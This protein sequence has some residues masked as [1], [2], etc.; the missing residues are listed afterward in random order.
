MPLTSGTRLGPYEVLAPLGAGGMGEVYRA[1]DTRLGREVAVKVLPAHLNDNPEVRARF[2]RE[3]RTISSLDHPH[4]CVL[5]DV[6]RANDTDYLVM[7]LVHGESLFDRL[8]RGPLPLADALRIG[9]EV[10]EALDRAHRAGVVHRDLKPANIMLAKSGAKLMDFGLARAA[11]PGITV[12]AGP[13]S[14]TMAHPLTAAGT[15]IGT[16]QYMAPEQLEGREADAR[17]D[18]WALGCVLYEMVAGRPA[19]GGASPA[20]ILSAI[21]KDE[22]RPLAELAPVAPSSLERIVRACLAKDPEQRWQSAHDLVLALRWP[23]GS[24]APADSAEPKAVTYRQLTF[25]RGCIIGARFASDGRT[26]VYDAAW[27]GGPHRIH[28]TRTDSPETT[29]PALPPAVLHG[30]SARS[31]LALSLDRHFLGSWW[32]GTGML[33]QAP[34]FGGSPREVAPGVYEAQWIAN[35]DQLAVIRRTGHVNVCE[36]PMGNPVY[37][38]GGWLVGLALSADGHRAAFLDMAGIRPGSVLVVADRDGSVRTVCPM[39][40]WNGGLAWTPDGKEI[41]FV[42]SKSAEGAQLG[43]VDLEGHRRYLARFMGGYLVLQDIAPSGELLMSRATHTYSIACSK[44]G[45]ERD[46]PLGQFDFALGKSLSEDGK[47]LLYDE[48]GVAHGGELYTYVGATDGTP[49][50]RLGAGYARALSPDGRWAVNIHQ[51]EVRLLPRGAGTV[52]K[53]DLGPVQAMHLIDWHP[54]GQR[55]VVLGNESGRAMRLWIVP[56]AGGTPRALTPEGI[57]Y[58]SGVILDPVSNDGTRVLGMSNAGELKVHDVESGEEVG[59]L[60]LDDGEEPIRWCEGDRAVFTWRRGEVPARVH[61]FDLA[62]GERTFW[63][64]YPPNDTTGVVCSRSLLLTADGETCVHTYSHMISELF[65]A[66]GLL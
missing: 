16:F 12:E 54:D 6:G 42:H 37:S 62:T 32:L 25:R 10:A 4:I 27:E 21:M 58:P 2:E 65:V 5:H 20:S 1:R 29:V 24:Q 26:V 19:F 57:G 3:A 63:R 49:P 39:E 9:A 14:P 48:Q 40:F 41:L 50:V 7:E 15:I 45:Q 52:R 8:K 66:R 11:A 28:I 53:V 34:L 46:V 64:E 43:V 36:F 55:L 17:S 38:S 61:R 33:A 18:L 31:E 35:T 30:V 23:Q 59:S 51:G 44:P 47:T 13:A 56:A 22:P 60:Q